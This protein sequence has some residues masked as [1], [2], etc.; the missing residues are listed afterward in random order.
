MKNKLIKEI[1]GKIAEIEPRLIEIRRELH[2]HP[3]PAFEEYRTA[4]LIEN[5][6]RKLDVARLKTGIAGT[7][8]TALFTGGADGPTIALRADMDGIQVEEEGDKP[9]KS[10]EDGMMHAC[11][12]DGHVAIL[13]GV[14]EVLDEIKDGLK[15]NV[16]LIFQPGEEGTGG[17]EPMIA[18]GV[19]QNPEVEAIFGLHI[20]LDLPAGTVGIKQGPAFAAI[21]EFDIKIQGKS[22]HAASPHQGVDSIVVSAEVINAFQTIV[23][24]VQDPLDPA[25]VTVG[26]IEAGTTHNVLAGS[27]ELQ[28]TARYLQEETGKKISRR[29]ETI[30]EKYTSAHGARFELDYRKNFPVLVNDG[31]IL[32]VVEKSVEAVAGVEGVRNLVKPTMGGED[33]AYFSRQVPGFFLFLGGRNESR[34][35]TAPHHSPGF[36]FDE[37]ILPLGTEIFLHIIINYLLQ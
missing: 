6:L 37:A 35:I 27:A 16:K 36:D 22:A 15:G 1:K 31:S 30:L 29:I 32:P 19:L 13:L 2:R 26:R 12:H 3:E 7:G 24:R 5:K 10:R 33:F 21:D 8:I 14:A 18:E 20:W 28:G 4:E 9:Y 34:G 23:S 25:V 11:G 17:A